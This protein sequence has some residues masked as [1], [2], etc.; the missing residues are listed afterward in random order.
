MFDTRRV[1]VKKL[2]IFKYSR[3][4]DQSIPSQQ[5]EILRMMQKETIGMIIPTN[6][7]P[8]ENVINQK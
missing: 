4:A 3:Q 6:R 5:R 7:P 8:G 2:Y 1:F